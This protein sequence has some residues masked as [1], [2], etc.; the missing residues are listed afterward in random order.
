MVSSKP[1]SRKICGTCE[2]WAGPRKVSAIRDRAE[3][4]NELV[5]G[6]CVGGGRDRVQKV[7]AATCNEWIKW[8][9]LK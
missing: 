4:E 2:H 7:V 1:S 6:E 5:Q 3:Y 8:G 9:V